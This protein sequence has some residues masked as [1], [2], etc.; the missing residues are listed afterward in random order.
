MNAKR[1]ID[2]I[3]TASFICDVISPCQLEIIDIESGGSP[4]K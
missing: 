4:A 2:E 1:K 3:N